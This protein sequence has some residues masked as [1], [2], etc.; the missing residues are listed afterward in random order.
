MIDQ[1]K[2]H[3]KISS[4]ARNDRISAL[5]SLMYHF[6]DLPDKEQA[7]NDI[8]QISDNDHSLKSI[9]IS[10][11]GRLFEYNT[12][13]NKSWND[14][15]RLAQKGYGEEKKIAMSLLGLVFKFAPD[16]TA[17]GMI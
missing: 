3:E 1:S 12:N 7:W 14:L 15:I 17:R 10:Y 2:L 11:L 16:K 4:N 9:S 6:T 5:Y 8:V 13:K